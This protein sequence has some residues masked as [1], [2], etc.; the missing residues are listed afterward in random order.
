MTERDRLRSSKIVGE[1]LPTICPLSI[2]VKEK[3]NIAYTR[4]WVDTHI[5]LFDKYISS[6]YL[7]SGNMIDNKYAKVT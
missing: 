7:D 5:Y 4:K 3:N 1:N 2:N 6:I